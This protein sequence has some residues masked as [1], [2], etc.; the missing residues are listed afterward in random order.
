MGQTAVNSFLEFQRDGDL[1]ETVTTDEGVTLVRSDEPVERPLHDSCEIL[2]LIS[3]TLAQLHWSDTRENVS[4]PPT[5]QLKTQLH[6]PARRQKTN[7]CRRHLVRTV[8]GSG[9]VSR[10]G[11]VAARRDPE[12]SCRH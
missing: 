11:I 9:D 7:D 12:G 4:L 10:A 5:R 8:R 6:D 3:M 1:G 2:V